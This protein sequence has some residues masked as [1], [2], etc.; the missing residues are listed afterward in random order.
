MVEPPSGSTPIMAGGD[1]LVAHPRVCRPR[2][3]MYAGI[4]GRRCLQDI[5]PGGP[6]PPGPPVRHSGSVRDR[7]PPSQIPDG[8]GS[9][10]FLDGD[11][12]VLYVGKAKSLRSRVSNYFADPATLPARTAQMVATADRVEWIQVASEVEAILLEY[13]LIKEHRPRFNIRLVDDKSYPWLALTLPD[14]WPRAGVVRG[15]RRP[16]IRYFGPFAHVGALRDTLDLLLRTFPIR[17]CSDSKLE[18]HIKLGRP[19]LM[20]HIE[21]CSGPCIGAV[22]QSEYDGLVED[23]MSFFAGATEEV[24]R[25]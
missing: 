4:P 1:S 18:R 9:Y 8:P 7:P 21:R 23:V 3:V 24:E 15:R 6:P 17:S 5:R 13:A 11:G 14:I 20:Y 12:R 16:G 2:N 25:R 10:Q 19:C 22:E